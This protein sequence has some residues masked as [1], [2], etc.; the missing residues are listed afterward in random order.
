MVAALQLPRERAGPAGTACRARTASVRR[1]AA[2]RQRPY[3]ST[4]A[5]RPEYLGAVHSALV[6][7]ELQC[8]AGIGTAHAPRG[9]ELAPL[10]SRHDHSATLHEPDGRAGSAHVQRPVGKV[11]SS[12]RAAPRRRTTCALNT[13]ELRYIS[14]FPRIELVVARA[15]VTRGAR[16]R[17]VS[18]SGFRTP[19][20]NRRECQRKRRAPERASR[21]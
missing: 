13:T 16:G 2:P 6:T 3:V 21:A 20:E 15:L 12:G 9:D 1:L 10:Q 11:D 19:R 17:R 14:P 18:W 4:H 5:L 8:S 7:A